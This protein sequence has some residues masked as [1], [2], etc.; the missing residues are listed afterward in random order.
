[1]IKLDTVE[2]SVESVQNIKT[3]GAVPGGLEVRD[4][5]TGIT[6]E[7]LIAAVA[8]VDARVDKA[9]RAGGE[10]PRI[11]VMPFRVT[12]NLVARPGVI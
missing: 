4:M 2:K 6:I 12:V 10:I 9:H 8:R 5:H 3:P 11:V 7:Q 1:M